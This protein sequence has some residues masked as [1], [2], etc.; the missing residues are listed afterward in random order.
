MARWWPAEGFPAPG[1]RRFA[2]GLGDL[3]GGGFNSTA[4]GVSADGVTIVGRG[5]SGA[6]TE[7]FR[8]T[9]ADGMG[10]LGD[11][12]DGAFNS[13]AYATSADGAVIVGSGESADGLEAFRWTSGGGMVG[14]G[15][16][17]GGIF[18]SR[19]FAVSADAAVVVGD[20]TSADGS[21]AFVWDVDAGMRSL[22]EV[23]QSD[24]GLDLTGWTLL[25]ARGISANG[26][27]IVGYGLNPA[28]AGEA[29]MARI[30][31]PA[32]VLLFLAGALAAFRRSEVRRYRALRP[33]LA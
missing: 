10:G 22:R 1:L 27:T 33:P 2:E 21:E 5:A 18:R 23:L 3:P 31:E 13:T 6:G 24:Y 14:L 29:W 26:L 7:A 16:L 28:G 4:F 11:L 17:P 20:S 12:P 8:W 32:S 19:A 15:D 30:P 25:A 9:A